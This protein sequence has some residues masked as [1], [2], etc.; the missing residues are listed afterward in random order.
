MSENCSSVA[1]STRYNARARALTPLCYS[2]LGSIVK[3]P[4][5]LP[6]TRN[7]DIKEQFSTF[8]M[9]QQRT[10]Y[11][12]LGSLGHGGLVTVFLELDSELLA[13]AEW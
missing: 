11:R 8:V 13:V 7:F 3:R 9:R 12:A 4:I 2:L 1:F 6:V 10:K 5:D